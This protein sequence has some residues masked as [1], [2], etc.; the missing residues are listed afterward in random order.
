M[1]LAE[2]MAPSIGH[3]N[4]PPPT[5][6]E[7]AQEAMVELSKFLDATPVIESSEQLVAAKLL[8]ERASGAMAELESERDNLVRPLN[9]EVA[10]I[11]AKYKAIHNTD[12]KKPG[13][14][15]KV[16]AVLKER[17]TVYAKAEEAKRAREAEL[18]RIEQAKAEHEAR[19]AERLEAE[20]KANAA[21]GE[22]DTNVAGA[23]ENADQKFAEFE[24]VS[25]FAARAEKNV[26]V[27]I[28]G[29][30]GNALSMRTTKTLVLESYSKALKA[31]GPCEKIEA[32]ILSAARDYRTE[33]GR[34]PEGVSETS[35]RK[36]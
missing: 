36:F 22:I 33:H 7:R 25:R 34:L 18:L 32:A 17:L 24:T 26:P 31:I 14:L 1:S 10:N 23:I 9:T 28:G 8:V 29:G 19:E 13:V 5:T 15:N 16:L 4:P 12:A 11:N 2:H 30:A 21:V 27:R 3:N 20:A 6:I 35:E